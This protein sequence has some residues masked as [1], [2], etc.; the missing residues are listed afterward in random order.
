[1]KSYNAYN[2]QLYYFN[3]LDDSINIYGKSVKV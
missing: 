2:M 3:Y 1:M